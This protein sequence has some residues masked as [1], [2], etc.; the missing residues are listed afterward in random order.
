LEEIDVLFGKTDV[1]TANEESGEK[2]VTIEE[3]GEER[4]V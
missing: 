1:A 3:E 2:G 4:Q